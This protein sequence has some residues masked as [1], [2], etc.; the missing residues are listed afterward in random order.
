MR[1]LSKTLPYSRSSPRTIPLGDYIYILAFGVEEGPLVG[2]GYIFDWGKDS[3]GE[4]DAEERGEDLSHL[5][6]TLIS[7]RVYYTSQRV[8]CNWIW[9]Q[10]SFAI[11]PRIWQVR[12]FYSG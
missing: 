4:S 10:E 9:I 1:R 8:G 2:R 7:S 5:Y 6:S 12:S 11:Y 3:K